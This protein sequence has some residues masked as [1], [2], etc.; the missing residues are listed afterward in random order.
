MVMEE[1]NKYKESFDQY[2]KFKAERIVDFRDVRAG[3]Q[4]FGNEEASLKDMNMAYTKWIQQNDGVLTGKKLTRQELQNRL[5]EDFGVGAVFKR[6]AVFFD[7]DGKAD[8]V[9]ERTQP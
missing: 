4:E 3:L 1:S 8:F 9:R 2:G 5:E 7:D 6:C